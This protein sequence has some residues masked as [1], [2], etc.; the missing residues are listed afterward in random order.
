M[1]EQEKFLGLFPTNF[2]MNI[3]ISI[4]NLKY[5]L[6]GCFISKKEK[7]EFLLK[8]NI[9]VEVAPEPED[10]IFENLQYSS[11]QR[12]LRI[13]FTYFL[14]FLIIAICLVI[15][16]LLN[17]VQIKKVKNS[18]SNVILIKYGLS[19]LITVV[20][21][22]V[23][24]IFQICLDYITK[25]EKQLSMTDLYLSLSI[26]LTIFTFITSA[27]V[28]L[29]S[30][31]YIANEGDYDLLVT[32]MTTIFLSNSL[33]TPIMWIFNFNYLIYIKNFHKIK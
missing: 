8:R 9:K 4:K 23:N 33:V 31:Y 17:S 19:L 18:N 5:F 24:F 12:N 26:K 20:V 27:I 21:S 14:S 28:P 29:V 15:I 10:V 30:N 7:K 3:L 25:I 16:L 32:N 6:C 1:E 13:I 22:T 11:R 2:I